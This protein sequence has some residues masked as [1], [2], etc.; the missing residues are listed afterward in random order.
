[1]LLASISDARR[2]REYEELLSSVLYTMASTALVVMT[3]FVDLIVNSMVLLKT[4]R[5]DSRGMLL[6]ALTMLIVVVAYLLGRLHGMESQARAD[7]PGVPPVARDP[8]PV[9]RDPKHVH[10]EAEGAPHVG[11][12]V[13]ENHVVMSPCVLLVA[14]LIPAAYWCPLVPLRRW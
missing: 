6:L 4:V 2:L 12:R 10:D 3:S 8:D 5:S 14:T 1:M 9:I 11:D 13:A 7:P